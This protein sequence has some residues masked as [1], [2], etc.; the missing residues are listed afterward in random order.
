MKNFPKK[1]D[2]P[3]V[4]NYII[5][6]TFARVRACVPGAFAFARAFLGRACVCACVR[7]RV[8]VRVTN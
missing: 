7:V 2:A 6:V 5:S 4:E 1:R 8:R 3:R